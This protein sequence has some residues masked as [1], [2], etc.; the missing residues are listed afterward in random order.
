V[1]IE[2]LKPRKVALRCPLSLPK[3]G[4]QQALDEEKGQ[5]LIFTN[6]P[7]S[8]FLADVSGD[9]LIDLVRICYGE[10]CYW[11]NLGYGRFG[12]KVTMGHSPWFEAPDVFDGR[13][14]RLASVEPF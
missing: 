13:R 1:S 4:V 8:I 10:V 2:K 5:K 11:P 14:I 12:T 6:G 9:D 7:E 3:G